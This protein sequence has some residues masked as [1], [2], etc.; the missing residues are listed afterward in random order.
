MLSQTPSPTKDS[1]ESDQSIIDVWNQMLK[2]IKA[3]KKHFVD[4][5]YNFSMHRTD[6]ILFKETYDK[7]YRLVI[8]AKDAVKQVFDEMSSLEQTELNSQRI[9]E[10]QSKLQ[11]FDEFVKK[12]LVVLKFFK[13]RLDRKFCDFVNHARTVFVSEDR[14]YANSKTTKLKWQQSFCQWENL[15][16]QIELLLD[17]VDHPQSREVNHGLRKLIET[18]RKQIHDFKKASFDLYE[19]ISFPSKSLAA[20]FR[21][22]KPAVQENPFSESI[23]RLDSDKTVKVVSPKS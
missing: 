10:L 5:Y 14:L 22:H 1:E 20:L 21:L 4:E 13:Q 12:E 11:T 23:K 2:R 9:R 16:E 18:E 15:I 8:G 19:K 7:W 17:L 6:E 3:I